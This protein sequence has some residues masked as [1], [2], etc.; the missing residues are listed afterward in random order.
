MDNLDFLEMKSVKK[1]LFKSSYGI[2]PICN[3]IFDKDDFWS[4]S[5]NTKDT[6]LVICDGCNEKYDFKITKKD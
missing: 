1:I 5:D 3:N 6:V 4:V 2:C